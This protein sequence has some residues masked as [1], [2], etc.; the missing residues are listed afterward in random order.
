MASVIVCGGGVIGL[1]TAMMLGRDGHQVTVLES[2]PAGVPATPA[3]AWESWQRAG[4]AQFRQP[5][6]LFGRFRQVVDDELPGL[7]SRLLAAAWSGRTR[8]RSCRRPSPTASRAPE[9]T[10]CGL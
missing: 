9:M 4:V 2:D 6:N 7:T 1:S 8:S 10:P 3:E 5:H